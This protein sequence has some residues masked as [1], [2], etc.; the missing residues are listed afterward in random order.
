MCTDQSTLV[1]FRCLVAHASVVRTSTIWLHWCG[2]QTKATSS[3]VSSSST[4]VVHTSRFTMHST[5]IS[6]ILFQYKK[7]YSGLASGMFGWVGLPV[8]FF[9]SCST[10]EWRWIFERLHHVNRQRRQYSTTPCCTERMWRCEFKRKKT[11]F[12]LLY[13]FFLLLVSGLRTSTQPKLECKCYESIASP[14]NFHQLIIT[15][16]TYHDN[17]S[18]L[19]A[20][21]SNPAPHRG[22]ERLREDRKTSASTRLRSKHERRRTNDSHS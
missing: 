11:I 2:L 8:C 7:H 12:F 18:N 19:S 22:V 10:E 5:Q 20:F 9:N 3:L 21:T 1:L 6:N 16:G 14:F 4:K 13:F 15:Y 17:V